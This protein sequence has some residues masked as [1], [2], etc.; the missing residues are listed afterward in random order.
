MWE[1]RKI[2]QFYFKFRRVKIYFIFKNLKMSIT[3]NVKLGLKSIR[4]PKKWKKNVNKLLRNGGK[5][6]LSI[7]KKIVPEKIFTPVENCCKNSVCGYKIPV[8]L[9]KL[10][11]KRFWGYKDYNLQNVFLESLLKFSESKKINGKHHNRL[12]NWNHLFPTQEK[13]ENVCLKFLKNVIQVSERRISTV[14]KK[15][16]SK[17]ISVIWLENMNTLKN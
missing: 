2:Y 4:N 5:E 13:Y 11:F 17:K 15:Y 7:T 9:Q 6:Y 16:C 14:K 3:K 10:V 12:V 8:D 1:L